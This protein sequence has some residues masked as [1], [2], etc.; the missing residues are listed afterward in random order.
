VELLAG[1]TTKRKQGR[2]V[3][4]SSN[5]LTKKNA[6][7]KPNPELSKGPMYTSRGN[8]RSDLNPLKGKV[9]HM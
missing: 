5:P 8:R 7:G 1:K 4:G 2:G 3:N 9:A 6:H